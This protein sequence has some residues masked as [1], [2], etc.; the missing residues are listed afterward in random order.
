MIAVQY[1]RYS[2]VGTVSR[3][4]YLLDNF[5]CC[6]QLQYPSPLEFARQV[7]SGTSTTGEERRPGSPDLLALV[8]RAEK[9]RYLDPDPFLDGSVIWFPEID[10]G[11]YSDCTVNRRKCRNT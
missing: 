3:Y 10:M 11:P 4:R 8:E 7:Y 9:V 5:L 2:T 6:S 1:R